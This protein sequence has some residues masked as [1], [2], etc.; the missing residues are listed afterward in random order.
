MLAALAL[1]S[2]PR[3]ASAMATLGSLSAG[4]DVLDATLDARNSVVVIDTRAG[5]EYAR[6]ADELHV[7]ASL[8]KLLVMVEVYRRVE[9]GVLSLDGSTVTIG[10]D[11]MT[12]DG[13]YTSAGTT[14]S[15]RAAVE[16]MITL[17]DNS[18]SLALVDLLGG[19][20]PIEDTAWS[21]GLSQTSLGALHGYGPNLTTAADIARLFTLLLEGRVVSASA[22]AQMLEVLAR[23]R[24]NDRLPA[25]LPQEVRVAHK[26]GDLA[27]V[28]HDAGIIWTPSGPRIVV[29]LAS[30]FAD[31]TAVLR[32]DASLGRAVYEAALRRFAAV[33]RADAVSAVS[34]PG[35]AVTQRVTVTNASSFAWGDGAMRL[36]AH[37]RRAD[38]G[39]ERWDDVRMALPALA[40]GATATLDATALA[41]PRPGRYILEWEPLIEGVAWSGD[42]SATAILVSPY[43]AAIGA[44]ESAASVGIG[45]QLETRLSV[46]N[47][48]V[49]T[50]SSAASPAINVGYHW[51]DAAGGVVHWDGARSPLGTIAAGAA[52]LVTARA[53]APARPGTYVLEWDLVAEGL[54]WLG[55]YQPT[56][57]VSVEVLAPRVAYAAT[58]GTPAELA[59]SAQTTIRVTLTNA[60]AAGWSTTSA[61]PVALSYHW[62]DADTGAV[63]VWD[64]ARTA[65]GTVG[66]GATRTVDA[67]VT[68]PSATGRY[69]LEWDVVFEGLAW[70]SQWS[71]TART[72]AITV[73]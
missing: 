7:M 4:L 52:A 5:Y 34:V 68:A 21:L 64:G 20:D 16:R 69:V 45:A 37:W 43:R 40:I 54:C 72:V 25:E 19:P 10:S 42:R 11:D 9:T 1:A 2:A 14:L 66:V 61:G 60:G 39:Y 44:L 62:R 29:S 15:V 49:V 46:R 32:F 55:E 35:A 51:R 50:L 24:V 73:R 30:D 22:S 33:V 26:T 8:Y 6:D 63:V 71:A 36:G 12:A 41:P 23:Q 38:G 13:Q 59:A 17:S 67:R 47:T 48:G 57:R 65:L 53:D 31:R 27:Y 18:P 70:A 56:A 28:S 3:P 58:G